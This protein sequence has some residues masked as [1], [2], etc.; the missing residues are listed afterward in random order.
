MKGASFVHEKNVKSL[1]KRVGQV[2]HPNAPPQQKI[3]LL[4]E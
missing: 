3:R 4:E 1:I 2:L